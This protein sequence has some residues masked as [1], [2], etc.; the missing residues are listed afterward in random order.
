MEA[1]PHNHEP[2]VSRNDE[3]A[4][5]LRLAQAGLYR[6]NTFRITGLPVEA[7]E[8]EIKRHADKMRL[9]EELGQGDASSAFAFPLTPPPSTG[10]IRDAL[11]RLTDPEHR[12]LDE[13]F[14]FWPR[15]AGQGTTDPA[16]QAILSGD[17]QKAHELWRE[18]ESDPTA[19]HIA[20][21]NL[22]VLYHLSAL[23]WTTH[24]FQGTL[25]PED[26]REVE[27]YWA[28]SLPRWEQ[29]AGDDRI[30]DFVRSR[31][32]TLDDPRLTT[33][34]VRRMRSSLFIAIN[35]INAETAVTF[36]ERGNPRWAAI[37]ARLS[38]RGSLPQD[39]SRAAELALTPIASRV[40]QHLATAATHT[41][42]EAGRTAAAR[43]LL[44]ACK[45]LLETF[46]LFH[47]PGSKSVDAVFN[48]VANNANTH[49]VVAHKITKDNAT[50]LA[51]LNE[52]ILFASS[53][54][55]RTLI[56]GN[57]K[58]AESNLRS[59]K[60][61]PYINRLA[62]A[63]KI[64]A[65]ASQRFTAI[66]R[67]GL[68]ML[69]EISASEGG[70]GPLTDEFSDLLAECFDAFSVEAYNSLHDSSTAYESILLASKLATKP[71][72]QQ[73]MAAHLAAITKEVGNNCCHFCGI[74]R[75][76]PAKASSVT[77]YGNIKRAWRRVE[78]QH[79]TVLVPR[80]G[81]CQILQANET[82]IGCS[83]SLVTVAL[84]ALIG[85]LVS[86][87]SGLLLGLIIGAAVG[88]ITGHLSRYFVRGPAK[89]KDIHDYPKIRQLLMTGWTTSQP[90]A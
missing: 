8:R 71:E 5:L 52:A 79:V 69:L 83:A 20:R 80:C 51:L 3:C 25:A 67:V 55:T 32:R 30:W 41:E 61:E 21:H 73:R 86:E 89:L 12:L 72:T 87:G 90:S 82:S 29:V 13:F 35:K 10:Q 66:Q 40:A 88:F 78:Y 42:K 26:E 65:T 23:D 36:S 63:R 53:P 74:N 49:L 62:A 2:G 1:E 56:E 45:P 16:V 34:F 27:T 46:L 9:M 58:V 59:N 85:Y 76:D 39:A 48:D 24:Q 57:I 70:H 28:E 75:P 38:R 4:P 47:E 77:L 15:E 6:E 44:D 54:D 84:G 37:H 11:R 50:F 81:P 31:V 22:A 19:N 14:W 33:G 68:P 17:S 60:L 64:G 18:W 7:S 43:T